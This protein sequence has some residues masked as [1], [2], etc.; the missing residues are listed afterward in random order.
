[1]ANAQQLQCRLYWSLSGVIAIQCTCDER[2]RKHDPMDNKWI[3]A[4]VSI[5]RPQ[6]YFL[7]NISYRQLS[8]GHF[9]SVV[10]Q[11]HP[12][13]I[14]STLLPDTKSHLL[15]SHLSYH[16]YSSGAVYAE[17]EQS[18][19]C[20]TTSAT[21]EAEGFVARIGSVLGN[22]KFVC[23]AKGCGGQTF[24]RPAELKRHHTTIHSN[25]KP[26]FWCHVPTC[27]RSMSGGGEAFH[28]KD[29]LVAHVQS[30][31]SHIR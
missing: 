23:D 30:K 6:P 5:T 16:R 1:V 27:R 9:T 22:G 26:D 13:T 12:V 11:P 21:T 14:Q 3:L 8:S 17:Q 31:H 29:K 18:E 25:N 7:A 28:R 20:R 15:T 19:A 24:T 4:R 10:S 2:P